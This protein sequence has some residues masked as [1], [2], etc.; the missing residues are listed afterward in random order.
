MRI[1]FLNNQIDNRGT[2]NAMFDY[3]HYNEEILGNESIIL[4]YQLGPHDERAVRR[5]QERFGNVYNPEYIDKMQL[6]ALYHIK[7]GQDDGAFKS[8]SPYLVHSVFDNNPHG[9]VYAT[10]SEW[11]AT[12]YNLPY[13][14]HIVNLPE[15]AINLRDSLGISKD[16]IVFGRHGGLDTFDIPWVWSAIKRVLEARSDVW[17]LMMSTN[18]P[19]EDLGNRVV[20][21]E[22]TAVPAFKSSFIEACDAMIHARQRGET[23]GIAV[24]EFASRGKPVVTWSGSGEKA[25]IQ[26]LG[27]GALLYHSED[28]LFE[29][30]DSFVPGYVISQGY[31]NFTPDKVMKKF[32][33]VF[34]DGINPGNSV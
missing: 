20:F 31:H 32:K 29:I 15:P 7:S 30:L 8:Y 5:Y 10:I 27:S 33:E 28:N 19:D 11:M 6:D 34:L 26:E 24:G 3:A 18:P 13:V 16:A 9:T 25:H 17:F 4:T 22:P 14:P 23:F 12:R 2:G 21:V 1:G